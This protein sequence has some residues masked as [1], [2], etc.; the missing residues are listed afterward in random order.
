MTP[1]EQAAFIGRLDE[2]ERVVLYHVG[3]TGGSYSELELKD[4]I[5]VIRQQ[6]AELTDLRRAVVDLHTTYRN[7]KNL[8]LYD[9]CTWEDKF[10]ALATRAQEAL[11]KEDGK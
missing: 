9:R 6:Q 8:S 10:D 5:S 4:A 2:I 3:S 1:D 7:R 11:R